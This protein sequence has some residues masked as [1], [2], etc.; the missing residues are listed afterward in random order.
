MI[1][2]KK[3]A[4]LDPKESF[5]L[6]D[7]DRTLTTYNSTVSWGLLEESPLIHSGYRQESISL[8]NHFRP[9]EIDQS[10]PFSEKEKL[11]EKWWTDTASLISKY[12]VY[13]STI[14]KILL[15]SN[16]LALRKDA[17][18][19]LS[20]MHLLGV[21]VVIV[22]AGLGDFISQ[23]LKQKNSLYDNIT[24]HAN[25]FLYEK[26]R[27][28]GLKKPLIHSL[29]KNHLTYPEI[30]GK[31]TGL[32]FG[33]QIE[34]IQMGENLDTI[35]IGFCDLDKHSLNAFTR[36]FDVVLTGRSSFEDVGK[37]Y[38]KRYPHDEY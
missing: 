32:L 10:I 31:K 12:H 28:I 6:M 16:G 30:E 13:E 7:F 26:G 35:N 17:L 1:Y 4:L 34:D 14:Q 36:R 19:F 33:D 9:M 24:I 18:S 20:N 21:P 8:Y 23:Y 38:M 22:S 5:V 15:S 37:I 2:I 11:M 3:R 27:I 29:N 25:F